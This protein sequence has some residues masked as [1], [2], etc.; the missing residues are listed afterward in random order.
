MSLSDVAAAW[1]LA[2]QDSC[3]RVGIDAS[4]GRIVPLPRGGG[5]WGAA[6]G[7]LGNGCFGRHAGGAGERTYSFSS[8]LCSWFFF[9]SL[10]V[11]VY[12]S[13][14]FFHASTRVCA[15]GGSE[16]IDPAYDR[17]PRQLGERS[18]RTGLREENSGYG[19]VGPSREKYATTPPCLGLD[20]CGPL[21]EELY[22]TQ[23]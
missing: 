18:R 3:P 22:P 13:I 17:F 4:A 1:A 14:F 9:S 5:G 11:D 15:R 10:D 21:L 19:D 12:K 23:A 8:I 6:G 16:G 7:A 2:C 20:E